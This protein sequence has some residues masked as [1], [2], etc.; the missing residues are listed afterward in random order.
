MVLMVSLMLLIFLVGCAKAPKAPEV[1]TPEV[2]KETPKELE[3]FVELED[4]LGDLGIE[5]PEDLDDFEI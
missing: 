1:P 3:D 5:E 2:P 4:V